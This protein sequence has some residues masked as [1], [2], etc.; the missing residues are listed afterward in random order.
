M[1]SIQQPEFLEE[2]TK[3]IVIAIAKELT[4]ARRVD[5]TSKEP[6]QAR[7]PT[8][9]NTLALTRSNLSRH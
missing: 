7:K 8:Q 3:G 6:E 1:Y 2:I 9:Q 5:I 4:V